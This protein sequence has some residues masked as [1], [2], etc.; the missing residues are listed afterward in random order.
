[1]FVLSEKLKAV[2][3]ALKS[4]N[5]NHFGHIQHSVQLASKA[6]DDIQ[7]SNQ[8]SSPDFE[9]ELQAHLKLDRALHLQACYWKDK[10]RVRWHMGGDRCTEF[11]H[12]YTRLKLA[13]KGI[14]ALQ[15]EGSLLTTQE[16]IE[17]KVISYFSDLYSSP[18]VCTP[19]SLIQEVIPNLV[20]HSDNGFLTAIPSDAEIHKAV[21]ASNA[22]VA[23][24]PDGFGCCF[25][26]IF[27]EVVQ[28]E[29]CAAVRQFFLSGWILLNMNSGIVALI[30]K[31]SNAIDVENFRPIAV[32]NFKFK[33]ITKILA[34]RL[35]SIAPKLISSQQCGFVKGRHI[36]DCI[37]VVSESV[38][39]LHKKTFGGNIALKL[40]IRK[41]FDTLDWKFILDVLRAFGFCETFCG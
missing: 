20:S 7:Q 37:G 34:D 4:W 28:K 27:W 6:L 12:R 16:A 17:G 38:N 10:S 32:A 22:D 30:S 2:K 39:I 18:N 1:M 13:T 25:F 15:H 33:I 40:D 31:S 11:F 35:A 3:H 24:G 5:R 29:V 41:A 36:F 23:P 14:P 26:Q 8:S 21:F 9:A 19:N